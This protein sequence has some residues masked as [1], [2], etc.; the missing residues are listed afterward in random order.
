METTYRITVN[1]AELPFGIVVVEHVLGREF[2]IFSFPVLS[3]HYVYSVTLAIK[4]CVN[5]T[6]AISPDGLW[7]IIAVLHALV[8]SDS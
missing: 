2:S 3:L 4:Q 7:P 6:Q 8:V 5:V 1:G